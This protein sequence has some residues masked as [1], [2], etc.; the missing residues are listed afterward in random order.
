MT[1]LTYAAL[2]VEDHFKLVREQRALAHEI[3]SDCAD[4]DQ[5][6]AVVAALESLAATL[7]GVESFTPRM[8]ALVDICARTALAGT[9]FPTTVLA[10]ESEDGQTRVSVLKKIIKAIGE[11]IAKAIKHLFGQVRTFSTTTIKVATSNVGRL[12]N[13]VD[14]LAK[15]SRSG[16]KFS[17]DFEYKLESRLMVENGSSISSISAKIVN[18]LEV[19]TLFRTINCAFVYD[20]YDSAR[21]VYDD[22][23]SKLAKEDKSGLLVRVNTANTKI[24]KH[25]ASVPET[26]R[27]G[28]VSGFHYTN[29]GG[30]SGNTLQEE[31]K[32][33]STQSGFVASVEQPEDRDRT[34]AKYT[35][36]ELHNSAKKVLDAYK[37]PV[38]AAK[39]QEATWLGKEG[40]AMYDHWDTVREKI[41]KIAD[42][43]LDERPQQETM[44]LLFT[45]AKAITGLIS[46]L[47]NH[48][49][50]NVV[51]AANAE[52]RML[53]A[54][55]T[56]TAAAVANLRSVTSEK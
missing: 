9:D 36:T 16:A 42:T 27:T 15:L 31:L 13:Y 46:T 51:A 24:S 32:K 35:V 37:K 8:E 7:G 14:E 5:S 23:L 47:R 26:K 43:D 1:T 17:A 2:P 11:F 33:F 45:Y 41:L 52:S 4:I 39:T 20:Y 53:A 44:N 48:T 55:V 56:T 30:E 3:K 21:W 38:T 12:E 29:K 50:K 54:F 40:Q 19:I 6:Q 34:T 25:L 10:L 49:A 22:A 28:A 18:D